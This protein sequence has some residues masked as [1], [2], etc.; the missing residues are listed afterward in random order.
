MLSWH[1]FC[2]QK[3]HLNIKKKHFIYTFVIISF[4]F[5][6]EKLEPYTFSVSLSTI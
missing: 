3:V 4:H 6:N 1:E 5:K 2:F